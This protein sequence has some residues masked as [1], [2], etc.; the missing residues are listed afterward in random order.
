MPRWSRL[1][2]I[3][4]AI[5]FYLYL[6][7]PAEPVNDLMI[8]GNTAFLALGR[9]GLAIVD[10]S[11]PEMPQPLSTF[12]TPGDTKAVSVSGQFVYLADGNQ[13]LR[14]VDV[15]RL[16]SPI[17]IG[18]YQFAGQALDV[19]VVND[20]V[21]LAA[22]RGGL[23]M[24][25]VASN[26]RPATFVEMGR[27][28]PGPSIR[29]VAV[30][31]DIAY[32]LA[33]DRTL[34]VVRISRPRQI[35]DLAVINLEL[36][37]NTL[38][39]DGQR[40]YLAAGR[41]GIQIFD[42]SR[43]AEPALVQ[44]IPTAGVIKDISITGG[45][46][47]YLAAGRE[48]LRIL[49]ISAPDQVSEVG[50]FTLPIDANQVF[51][52][53]GKVYLADRDMGLYILDP[54][55]QMGFQSVASDEKRRGNV[56]DVAVDDHYAYLASSGQG[57]RVIDLSDPQAPESVAE[58]DTEG[59]ATG[60]S[61][62][63]D[64]IY[65]AD[66]PNGVRVLFLTEGERNT[67]EIHERTSIPTQGSATS[68]VLFG[69]LLYL[70]DGPGGLGI[71]DLTDPSSPQE[72]GRERS[73]GWTY[74]VEVLGDYAYLASGEAGLR[75]INVLDPTLPAEVGA[76]DT[77]GEAHSL[78][79]QRRSGNPEQILIYL[80][81]G[82]GGLRVIDITDPRSPREVASLD[83]NDFAYDI[84]LA[85]DLA[86]VTTQDKG[87]RAISIAD[88]IQLTEVG[89]FDTPGQAHGLDLHAGH[90]FIADFNRGLRV[91]SLENPQAPREIGF[92]EIHRFVRKVLVKDDLA[93]LSDGENGFRIAD[94]TNPRRPREVGH[95]DQGGLIDDFAIRDKVAFIASATGIQAVDL[96][97]PRNPV[98]IS[99]LR[100]IGR[101]FALGIA[102]NHAYLAAGEYGLQIVD[103]RDPGNMRLTSLYETPGLAQDIFLS[104]NYAYIADGEA[105]LEIVLVSDPQEPRTAS[106]LDQFKD[107]RS[108]VVSSGYAYLADG[109]NG[110][111]VIDVQ[112]PVEPRIVD[113]I[114]VDG[115]PVDLEIFGAYLFVASGDR[116][117]Q[118]I[119]IQ[120][121]M[122][123]RVIG[124]AQ[125]E[126]L[127]LDLALNWRPAAG[128][129]PSGLFVFLAKNEHGLEILEGTTV[130][131]PVRMGFY[132]TP[133][134]A[135]PE[136]V[137][138]DGFPIIAGA[139][140]GKSARTFRAYLF[141]LGVLGLGGYLF[142]TAVF[143]QF[144]LPLRRLGD[145]VQA[146]ERLLIYPLGLHG[147]AVRIEN[148]RVKQRPGEEKR[149]G[150]GVI[151]LDT[152][153]A[154]M[155]RTKTAF[156]RVIGPGVVFTK[157]GE[158]LHEE[159]I[160]LHT[161]FYPLPPLGP[162]PDQDPFSP[163]RKGRDGEDDGAYQA[164]QRRRQE[165]SALTRDGIEVV[166]RIMTVVKI[167][168]ERGQGGTQFG[169]DPQAVRLA[170]TRKGIVP[171][172][173]RHMPWYEIPAYMAVDIWREYLSKFTLTELFETD[174]DRQAQVYVSGNQ[175]RETRLETVI[176]LVQE[177]L[178]RPEVDKLDSYGRITPGEKDPSRE[179][180]L[181]KDMGI[182]VLRVS[183]G[184][185]RFP[186]AVEAQ[187][188]LQWLSTWQDRAMRQRE[189]VDNRRR[190]AAIE[191]ERDATLQFAHTV[192]KQ[193]G[194]QI[195]QREK[196]G[197]NSLENDPPDL[198]DSLKMLL[199]DTCRLSDLLPALHRL[200]EDEK[201]QLAW[202]LEWVR[203]GR[204]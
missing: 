128:N 28:T 96:A 188:V 203:R 135:P 95:F 91:L 124:N 109:P 71:Y 26:N 39:V 65:L 118:V 202:L 85:G 195:G 120:D 103:I 40:L 173:L 73:P 108:V 102:E 198:S 22:G 152:A 58:Y 4:G 83:L 172:E 162:E 121:P 13:G 70:A 146:F 51:V 143:A 46:F 69:Q 111:W 184:G 56:E 48:G 23:I 175:R 66:G 142:W 201:N 6:S 131:A 187:L 164:R 136:Q 191:G 29:K 104:G 179:Y 52:S 139:D 190:L 134:M 19:V 76:F 161:H 24:L 115:I 177:R 75:V 50:R 63:G 45:G 176:R 77:P 183:I 194:E 42:I 154:A 53:D 200:T 155:L 106:V 178:T 68:S 35:E 9:A 10:V 11:N 168:A 100:T 123:P 87:L 122:H 189:E 98:A 34:R 64:F 62:A 80:A 130:A 7:R 8:Y 119:Y 174:P 129:E 125:T 182:S 140:R 82:P 199:E 3:L 49:D 92:F 84:Q 133:G 113:L 110:I 144:V 112:E 93:F 25:K 60:V 16:S 36:D 15:S 163:Q 5:G 137:I 17:E 160:D 181:L 14:L 81:D 141:D 156:S 147:P 43:P 192:T 105:G 41:N 159:T 151:L 117:V 31:G 89:S 116:G 12:D 196:E 33:S 2:V 94:V 99:G 138:R 132:Q 171:K 126:G 158:Y 180:Q 197:L 186:P 27:H 54:M 148:G 169:F 170:I 204:G 153:S 38:Q 145:R 101:P 30:V 88:L 18:V 149:R 21:Y 55:V 20:L 150:P 67:I 97:D 79:V 193:I 61:L 44:Q 114:K 72:L 74:D 107:A 59:Q 166:A 167:R 86:Y 37:A 78:V 127:T 185:V 47:A 157:P 90:A 57:L 32:L 1:I 165:T